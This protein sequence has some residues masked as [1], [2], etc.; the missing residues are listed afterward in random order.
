MGEHVEHRQFFR[1]THPPLPGLE[2]NLQRME[3]G[4]YP[5]WRGTPNP[6]VPDPPAPGAR[7]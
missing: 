2:Q 3:R 5:E 7:P 4:E 1:D 6:V